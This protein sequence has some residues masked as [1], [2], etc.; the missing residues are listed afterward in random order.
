MIYDDELHGKEKDDV[1]LIKE[2]IIIDG[3]GEFH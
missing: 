2:T 3:I 1:S